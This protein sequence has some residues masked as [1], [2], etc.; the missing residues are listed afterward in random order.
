MASS[1]ALLAMTVGAPRVY[2]GRLP[3]SRRSRVATWVGDNLEDSRLIRPLLLLIAAL[4]A[5]P[6]AA[7]DLPTIPPLVI[8][9]HPQPFDWKGLYV[10]SGVTFSAAKGQKGQVGGDVFAG[11]DKRFDNHFVLGVRFDTGYQP[12]LL[13]TGRFKG[14]DFAET[15]VKVGYEMGRL[16]PYVTL[17]GGLAKATSFHSGLPDADNSING[18][19]YGPGAAQPVTSVGGGFDYALT[20]NV[21]VGLSAHVYN[22]P[23]AP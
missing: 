13:P 4:L 16:T 1:Q 11:Y 19:F 2:K 14:F 5:A 3:F 8:D 15:S 6:A 12:W 17:G 9:P 20:N 23:G 10:G 22:G 18:L 21:R 7:A